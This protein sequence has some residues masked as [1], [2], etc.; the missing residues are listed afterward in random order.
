MQI[1]TTDQ[2]HRNPKLSHA[3][4]RRARLILFGVC[5]FIVGLALGLALAG[6]WR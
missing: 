4:R 3:Q 6:G 2:S 5:W 1:I